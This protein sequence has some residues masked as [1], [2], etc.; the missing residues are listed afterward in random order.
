MAD[1][2]RLRRRL[3]T[4]SAVAL[5]FVAVTAALPLLLV[6][7]LLVDLVRHQR[8]LSSVRVALFIF[9]YLA[10]ECVCLPRLG[11][12]ALTTAAGS[13]ARV[14]RTFAAQRFF[15]GTL[16]R[17]VT[18]LFSLRFVVE[19]AELVMPGPVLVLLRHASLVDVLVPAGFIANLHHLE[20]RYVLKR[21]LLV[22]PLLD[23]AG[24]W[25]PNHFVDRSGKNT[26]EEL[27]KIAALKRGLG[28]GE[29][30]I[31]YPEGTRFSR[32]R[33]EALLQKLEGPARERAAQLQH[34]LPVQPGGVLTLLST[35]PAT[36][37]LFV[38]HHGLE[39][40]TKLDDIWRGRM[41]GRTVTI[42]F[43]R[44]PAA[45][46]PAGDDARLDWVCAKWKRMDEWLGALP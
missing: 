12:I 19:G 10:T 46:L 39:G 5:A 14:E 1:L 22:D 9:C 4:V 8:A 15:T 27:Q 28:A 42:R 23:I 40:L 20:L 11:W 24:H 37:V 38:G 7:A 34:L 30:V 6:L 25:L 16:L 3:V 31:I 33:R 41:V 43:W 29:G 21:E 36:D 32:G 45:G 17:C 2:G 26:A 44:E 35:A 13:R 18:R